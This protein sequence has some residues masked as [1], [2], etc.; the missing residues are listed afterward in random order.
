MIDFEGYKYYS[1]RLFDRDP[2]LF[3]YN[4]GSRSVTFILGKGA[5]PCSPSGKS[6]FT[7]RWRKT[8]RGKRTPQSFSLYSKHLDKER[9]QSSIQQIENIQYT[10][11]LIYIK[12]NCSFFDFK[13]KK[14]KGSKLSSSVS[15]SVL[16]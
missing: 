2:D 5:A 14:E 13:R 16:T 1:Y 3:F 15:Y 12:V 11:I 6:T 10:I 4:T 9:F 8:R 7:R